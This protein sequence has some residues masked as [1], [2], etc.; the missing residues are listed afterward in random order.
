MS[1]SKLVHNTIVNNKIVIGNLS[2]DLEAD[3]VAE[4]IVREEFGQVEI[5]TSVSGRKLVPIRHFSELAQRHSEEKRRLIDEKHDIQ[6]M[7]L[8]EN[9]RLEKETRETA[10]AEGYEKGY[11]E[12]N[13]K[14]LQDGQREAREVVSNFDQIIKDAVR[15]REQLYLSAKQSI[16]ELIVQIARKITFD[17]AE[18]D[19]EITAGIVEKVLEKLTDKTKVKVKVNPAHLPLLEQQIERFK[20]GSTTIKEFNFEADNRV[21]KGGCY[22]ET[23][24]GDV[25]VRLE[26]QMDIIESIMKNGGE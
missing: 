18:I 24:T 26:T 8:E 6:E 14:G 7:L 3:L 11:S 1:L 5:V 13:A 22:I 20:S 10:Y 21:R 23:P 25:D 2:S 16:I 4:E 17:T 9:R 12:G 15:Q 19:P